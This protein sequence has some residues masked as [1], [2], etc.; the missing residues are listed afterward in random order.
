MEWMDSGIAIFIGVIL[1]FAIPIGATILLAW[2]FR[3]LDE[4][5][6]SEAEHQDP[7]IAKNP[8]CWK[9]NK[10]SDSQK[11]KCK[12]YAD[13]SKPC[14]QHFREPNGNLQERCLGCDVFRKAPV[15]IP[16]R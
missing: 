15:P 4:R 11:A 3:R 1:R 14:W 9:V 13:P 7:A 8:G 16:I 6:Q 12:A 5:W 10:C 2:F